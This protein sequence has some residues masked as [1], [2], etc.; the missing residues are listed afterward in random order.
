MPLRQIRRRR[1][2]CADGTNYKSYG[3]PHDQ[4]KRTPTSNVSV[5]DPSHASDRTHTESVGFTSTQND[6]PSVGQDKSR[7]TYNIKS[8]IICNLGSRPS[9]GRRAALHR[10]TVRTVMFSS[11]NQF[12]DET[13]NTSCFGQ[14]RQEEVHLLF[15]LRGRSHIS[16]MYVEAAAAG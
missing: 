3:N 10:Q 7:T 16:P 12:G 14:Q 2:S 1:S 9:L 15:L 8:G 13:S 5:S 11:A 6:S 4:I